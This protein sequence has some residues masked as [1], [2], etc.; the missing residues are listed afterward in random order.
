V[1]F[2]KLLHRDSVFILASMEIAF[3][4]VVENDQVARPLDRHLYFAAI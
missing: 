2:P 3:K 1:R 4:Y